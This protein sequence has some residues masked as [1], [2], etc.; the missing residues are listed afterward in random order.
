[1]SKPYPTPLTIEPIATE[2][3][4]TFIILHGRGSN[5]TR[6][7]HEL[8]QSA[9]LPAQLPTVKFIFP[10][11]RRRRSTILKRV[12]INQWFD[13][14]SLEDPG[15]RTN[16]QVEG[17]CETAAFLR[18]LIV[19]EARVLGE[20]GDGYQR[21]V[22]GGLS[23][24]CAAGV[25][26]LLGGG[27][28]DS[29][30]EKLGAFFG[31][32]GWLPFEAELGDILRSASDGKV[33]DSLDGLEGS[34]QRVGLGDDTNSNVD[35]DED[36]GED[37]GEVESSDEEDGSGVFE[38]SYDQDEDDFNPFEDD[39]SSSD[40]NTRLSPSFQVINHVR[41]ILDLP[42]L[43]PQDDESNPSTAAHLD[44]PVFLGHG[45]ADPKVSVR[46]GQKMAS[47]LSRLD[48]NVTWKE[49]IGFGHWYKVPDEIDDVLAFL[50]YRM[51]VPVT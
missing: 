10:T 37:K 17:L 41:D 39:V 15:Q 31:M 8:L 14:Y 22:L 43:S 33:R 3:T 38:S 4:H 16:L 18:T 20:N 40:S 27:F 36:E 11:A 9:N 23:Q 42:Q 47:L 34:M 32:S 25:F 29:G 21:I 49:Y 48:M 45:A 6:F 7:G 24:G 28:G 12:P 19:Q 1:M 46:L 13:N 50:Q 30:C 51:S 44:I 35:T 5:A 26:A 2:H